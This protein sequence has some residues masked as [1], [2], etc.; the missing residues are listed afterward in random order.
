LSGTRT[1]GQVPKIQPISI[2]KR[3]GTR[4]KLEFFVHHI[5]ERDKD[6]LDEISIV[7]F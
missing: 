5:D 7:V 3:D 6:V 2:R 4:S 1:L